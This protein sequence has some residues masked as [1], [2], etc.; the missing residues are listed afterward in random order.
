MVKISQILQ[1]SVKLCLI[2]VKHWFIFDEGIVPRSVFEELQLMQILNFR[3]SSWNLK[4][5]GL[6]EK[7]K[8]KIFMVPFY[9]WGSTA[10]R[11][12]ALWGGSLLFTTEF[13]ES[14]GT[15]FINLGRM[16]GWVNLGATQWIWTRDPWIG[17]PEPWPVG[18]YSLL[19]VTFS[20][21]TIIDNLRIS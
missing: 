19:L 13:L 10:S 8:K 17:N 3:T 7:K 4:I 21:L 9:G 20:L 5:R 6:G 2:S 1:I 15:R 12:K 11:L 18:H 16:K 14:P